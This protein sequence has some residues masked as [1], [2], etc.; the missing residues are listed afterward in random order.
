M[1]AVDD[2]GDVGKALEDA[3]RAGV[4]APQDAATVAL[5]RRMAQQI[6]SGADRPDQAGSVLLR[7][8]VELQMTPKARS[9]VMKGGTSNDGASERQQS[10]DE[11]R[12]RRQRRRVNNP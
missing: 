4:Q 6:D 3:L 9:A 10:L 7:A 5:A 11:L 2:L 1:P 12:E 8:L